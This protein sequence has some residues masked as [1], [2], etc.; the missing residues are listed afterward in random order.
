MTYDEEGQFPFQR[1]I[2]ERLRRCLSSTG[3]KFCEAHDRQ[4]SMPWWSA[5]LSDWSSDRCL[6]RSELV[7]PFPRDTPDGWFTLYRVLPT[8]Q[9]DPKQ[10]A[11]LPANGDGLKKRALGRALV[12]R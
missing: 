4:H 12:E 6:A 10:A 2:A 8:P 11:V 9:A 3:S 1:L 7:G 5:P